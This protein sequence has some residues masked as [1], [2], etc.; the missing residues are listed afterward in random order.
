MKLIIIGPFSSITMRVRALKV[1][2][3]FESR[4]FSI[5]HWGW[6]REGH[7]QN[8][9][10]NYEIEKKIILKTTAKPGVLNNIFYVA[11]IIR[12]FFLSFF[13]K[14]KTIVWAVGFESAF[15]IVLASKIKGFKLVF[16]DADRFSMLI[17]YPRPIEFIIQKFEY[18]TSIICDVHIIPNKLRYG[19]NSKKFFEMKNMPSQGDVD[20]AF[21]IIYLKQSEKFDIT[22]Y[23]NGLLS[24]VRGA[25]TLSRVAQEL[26]KFTDKKIRFLVAGPIRGEDAKALIDLPNVNYLGRVSNIES[27]SLY[28]QS[29][30]VFTYYSPHMKINQYAES[31]KWGDAMCMGTAVI[32][33][34]EVK[35]KEFLVK[36]GCSV[37]FLYDEVDQVVDYLKHVTEES[38]RTL[39]ENALVN[40]KKYQKFN[41]NLSKVIE[42]LN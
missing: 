24:D 21:E 36:S 7:D 3:Y 32:V 5:K 31:N 38:I 39:K 26:V 29:D 11:W 37:E 17:N 14:S 12:L 20:K 25:K 30:Y 40:G 6:L 23:C 8:E 2:N 41:E 22:I 18:I 4:G 1:A 42:I 27:L 16:D 34:S 33:N 28:K 10:M 13:I 15:P 35:T 19:F 9:S